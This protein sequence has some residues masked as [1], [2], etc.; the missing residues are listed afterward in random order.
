MAHFS[1]QQIFHFIN[2][3]LLALMKRG[4]IPWHLDTPLPASG[5]PE[6]AVT[7]EMFSGINILLLW[8]ATRDNMLPS[9]RWLTGDELRAVGGRL[10]DSARP[11]T[12]VR[13]RPT[14]SL[15]KVANVAQC[16]GLPAAY[17]G[18]DIKPWRAELPLLEQMVSMAE[19]PIVFR[20]DMTSEP[21]CYLPGPDRIEI[22]PVTQFD[23]DVGFYQALLPL[24]VASSGHEQRLNI[25]DDVVWE[26]VKELATAFLL[27]R[28]RLSGFRSSLSFV[29]ALTSRL[30]QDESVLFRAGMLASRVQRYLLR[31]PRSLAVER[32]QE[33]AAFLT[34]QYFDQSF[35]DTSLVCESEVVGHLKAGNS[36]GQAISALAE[37]YRWPRRSTLTRASLTLA[38]DVLALAEVCPTSLTVYRR[39]TERQLS[40]PD[41]AMTPLSVPTLSAVEPV[42]DAAND[43]PEDDGDDPADNVVELPSAATSGSGRTPYRSQFVALFKRISPYENR[44]QVF[45]DFVHMAAISLYNSIF[46]NEEL[47]ADYMRRVK[48]YSK[49]DASRLAELMGILTMGLEYEV[50]DFLG[51]IFM[52]LE[53]SSSRI[54]QYFTPYSVSYMMGKIQ[55]VPMAEALRSGEREY[56]T[57]SDPACGGGA[58]II[59]MYQAMLDEGLNPQKQMFAHCVDLDPVAAMMTY[60]QLSLLGL[61]AVVVIGNSLSQEFSRHLV[62]PMYHLGLWRYKLA[63][64][65]GI[66]HDVVP[67]APAKGEAA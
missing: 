27:A 62:T 48:R 32:W 49:E 12:I 61:P 67:T 35:A 2:N 38:H 7:G 43:D 52:E 31:E 22:P 6:H 36:P 59:G 55:M 57:V 1:H 18:P 40:L 4:M 51:S 34:G 8:Q 46:K 10:I 24:L 30:R 47:E 44:W 33:L 25:P 53:L 13:F 26:L 45:S 58:M 50:C 39:Q 54:G 19:V 28:C 9:N 29:P 42:P 21:A 63:R 11:T 64:D 17:L 56:V 60:V 23:T 15:M 66:R 20:E 16:E 37:L 14:L 65:E 3:R 41:D 5:I